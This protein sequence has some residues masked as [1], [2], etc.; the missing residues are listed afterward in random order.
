M[1]LVHSVEDVT[2]DANAG[3]ETTNEQAR[4][5]EVSNEVNV[6]LGMP[7]NPTRDHEENNGGSTWVEEWMCTDSETSLDTENFLGAA[8]DDEEI[9]DIW[10][11]EKQK[12]LGL[13]ELCANDEVTFEARSG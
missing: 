11:K 10:V 1:T 8:S 7:S 2:G 9:R 12:K 4:I 5:D 6:R 13:E 3:V